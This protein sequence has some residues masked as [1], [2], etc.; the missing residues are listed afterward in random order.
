MLVG[1]FLRD[2]L[3]VVGHSPVDRHAVPKGLLIS[4]K[5][6][7]ISGALSYLLI[8]LAPVQEIDSHVARVVCRHAKDS[9]SLIFIC[10]DLVL[11]FA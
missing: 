1:T 7:P 10:R 4:L 11:D 5:K 2:K 9:P 6:L 8:S 3:H